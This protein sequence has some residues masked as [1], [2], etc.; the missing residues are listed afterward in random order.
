M[1]VLSDVTDTLIVPLWQGDE[2]GDWVIWVV[3]ETEG[4]DVIEVEYVEEPDDV[5]DAVIVIDVF[6]VY[7]IIDVKVFDDEPV[8]VPTG[9]VV[10]RP[11]AELVTVW[12]LTGEDE[13]VTLNEGVNTVVIDGSIEID[14][15]VDTDGVIVCEI[16]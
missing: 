2:L 4:H 8:S 6:A 1:S 12:L 3:V 16:L 5:K 11:I 9:V 15:D 13:E 7:D 14:D 10:S